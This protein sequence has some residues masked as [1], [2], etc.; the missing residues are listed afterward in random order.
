MRN[1]KMTSEADNLPKTLNL[2][3]MIL[4]NIFL[5]SWNSAYESN[6]FLS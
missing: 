2:I 1:K 3:R 5:T 4:Y 6:D